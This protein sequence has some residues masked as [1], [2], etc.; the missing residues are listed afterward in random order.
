LQGELQAV[1]FKIQSPHCFPDPFAISLAGDLFEAEGRLAGRPGGEVSHGA[2][3][4]L[5]G[6][7]QLG[8][9]SLLC[10]QMNSLQLAGEAIQKQARQLTE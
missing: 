9:G 6:V 2:L 8:A 1:D 5:G 10:S 3:Q 4:P 7:F